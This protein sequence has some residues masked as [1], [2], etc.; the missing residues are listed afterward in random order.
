[1]SRRTPLVRDPAVRP[2]WLAFWLSVVLLLTT[3]DHLAAQPFGLL[4]AGDSRIGL[5][6]EY[7]RRDLYLES[8]RR[9]ATVS[10]HV[11]ALGVGFGFGERVFARLRGM[12]G[13]ADDHIGERFGRDL[14]EDYYLFSLGGALTGYPYAAGDLRIGATLAF[15]KHLWNDR[16]RYQFDVEME[17]IAI[18]VHA[19][20]LV[21]EGRSVLW[22]GPVYRRDRIF[23][24]LFGL[25]YSSTST[26][27]LGLVAGAGV[28]V[29]KR[30]LPFV[31][32]V[33][34]ENV[35]P[36]IGVEYRF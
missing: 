1:M 33:V 16:S 35:Q 25:R 29:V 9:N 32:V 6:Y 11:P 13:P 12:Y 3:S 5:F 4:D 17:T 28:V 7:S 8:R 21:A 30:L 31:Q 34:L 10:W 22:L 19:E 23:E 24:H 27:N 18:G 20:R 15:D 2:R 36:R 26:G 14:D